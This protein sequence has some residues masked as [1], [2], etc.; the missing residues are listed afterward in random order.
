VQRST[1]P[2]RLRG[3]LVFA[4]MLSAVPQ[5]M[6][7]AGQEKSSLWR[8]FKSGLTYTTTSNPAP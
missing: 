5:V 2:G 8:E 7:A 1:K 6:S 4:L 3:G